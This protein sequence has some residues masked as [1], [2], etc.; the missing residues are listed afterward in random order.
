MSI[1]VCTSHF[2]LTVVHGF[3]YC[4]LLA[5]Y[6][7]TCSDCI[8]I[9]T[10]VLH[11]VFNSRSWLLACNIQDMLDNDKWPHN[12]GLIEPNVV[13]YSCFMSK[14]PVGGSLR[15]TY[16]G[17][18][19]SEASSWHLSLRLPQQRREPGNSCTGPKTYAQ[20]EWVSSAHS[21]LTKAPSVSLLA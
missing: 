21:L 14:I 6:G 11:N 12:S 1:K 4:I 3:S 10:T 16:Q 5:C 2:I 7:V 13:S 19:P 17:Q 18:R 9:V 20:N 15:Y 8:S